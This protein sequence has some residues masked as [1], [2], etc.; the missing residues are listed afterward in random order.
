MHR[1]PPP[2]CLVELS[3]LSSKCPPLFDVGPE[4]TLGLPSP[5]D[6]AGTA[7]LLVECFYSM[8]SAEGL[9]DDDAAGGAASDAMSAAR[10]AAHGA[11]QTTPVAATVVASPLTAAPKRRAVPKS[12]PPRL[13]GATVALQ[14]RWRTASRGLQWRLAERL[15]RPSVALS[16]EASLLLA[17]RVSCHY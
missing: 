7:G 11:D 4:F 13:A 1:T 10:D 6:V 9:P 15:Q 17:L 12:L 2:Q 14:E 5:A 16:M 3:S 8:H